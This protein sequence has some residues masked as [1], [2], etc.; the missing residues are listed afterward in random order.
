MKIASLDTFVVGNPPPHEGGRYFVFLKLTTDDGVT[1][2]GE[3]YAA[4]FGPAALVAMIE[5]VFER[6][7]AGADPFHIEALWRRVYGRGYSQRP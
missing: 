1:G 2:I 4:S 3:V 5:D 7:V 6:H